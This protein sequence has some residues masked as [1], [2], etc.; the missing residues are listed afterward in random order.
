MEFKK[1]NEIENTYRQKT[2]DLICEQ[3]LND[4]EWEVSN[5]IHGANFSFWYDG[6]NFKLAK[7]SGFIGEGENFYN[8]NSIK[9]N[10]LETAKRVWRECQNKFGQI[11]QIAVYGELFGGSYPNTK[12]KTK[13]VQ[14][15]VYYSP[16]LE[17]FAFDI[18]VDSQYLSLDERLAIFA[19]LDIKYPK[20]L[21]RGTFENCLKFNPVFEDP[22]YLQLNLEKLE[23]NFSE[24]VVIKPCEPKFFANGSRVILKNKNPKFAEKKPKE[25]VE[26]APLSE[27]VE[28]ELSNI[29]QFITE[30][31]LKNVLSKIG[32]VTNKDFGKLLSS[33]TADVMQDYQK[34]YKDSFDILEKV[35]QSIIKKHLGT[36]SAKMIRS[37]FLN[38]IDGIF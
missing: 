31:R 36:K 30:N 32:A 26:K 14:K 15:G 2:I 5:K 7:R 25:K 17:F 35:D 38:I 9:G 29:E 1:Y 13:A 12:S 37:N 10:L 16:E 22:T 27:A 34:E 24:G 28:V 6:D 8:C 3:N 33:F 23:G 4:G 21:F 20:V 18:L 11:S 19:S